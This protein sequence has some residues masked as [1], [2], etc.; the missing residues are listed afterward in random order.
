MRIYRDLKVKTS[1]SI[2]PDPDSVK[3]AIKR[4]NLP[5]FQWICCC[6][7]EIGDAS[8]KRNGW[9]RD[10]DKNLFVPIWFEGKQLPLSL[11]LKRKTRDR[12]ASS[13]E[14]D[15]DSDV[16]DRDQLRKHKKIC[17]R[18]LILLVFPLPVD[19]TKESEE[20]E[21]NADV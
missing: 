18:K 4:V 14:E 3:Q 17:T 10:D 11:S 13:H 8:F 1:S 16:N 21:Y 15:D 6:Q 19:Q 7:R 20:F 5:V 12:N 9:K 2:P